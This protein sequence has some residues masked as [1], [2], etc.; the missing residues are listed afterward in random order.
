MPLLF[1]CIEMMKKP[2]IAF[3]RMGMP[4]ERQGRKKDA[5]EP[6]QE[7]KE[8]RNM[9]VSY[10]AINREY[11]NMELRE[12]YREIGDLVLE[13]YGFRADRVHNFI[14]IE[15]LA[16]EGEKDGYEACLGIELEDI[17]VQRFKRVHLGQWVVCPDGETVMARTN[18]IRSDEY[19][20][21]IEM[22]D[23]YLRAITA[24]AEAIAL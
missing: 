21:S 4:G 17:P 7:D 2:S 22:I 12:D 1:F 20:R 15:A 24:G 10:R 18:T 19:L 14:F 16:P 5:G 11:M 8:E 23:E 9:S 6:A 3:R 13:H